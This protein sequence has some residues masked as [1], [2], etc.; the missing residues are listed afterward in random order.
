MGQRLSLDLT[1]NERGAHIPG[2]DRIAGDPGL[3]EFEG[4]TFGQS[5][6][7]VFSLIV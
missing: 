7:R 6:L 4:H 5:H 1:F 2:T 3:G